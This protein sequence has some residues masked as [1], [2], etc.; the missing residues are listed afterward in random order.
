MKKIFILLM[1]LTTVFITGCGKNSIDTVFKDLTEKVNKLNSYTLS[2]NLEVKN[3]NNSYNYDVVVSFMA[4]DKFRVSLV[5]TS[6]NHEQVI[7]RNDEGVFVLTPSLNKSFKFQSDWP[8]N[9]SQIY[10][11]ASIIDDLN[12]DSKVEKV[13]ENG[14]YIFT[15]TVKYPNNPDLVKQ[16]VTVNNEL[17]IEKVE[18]LNSKNEAEM[19]FNIAKIDYAPTFDES[20]FEVNN[21]INTNTNKEPTTDSKTE[22]ENNTT[23]K[24]STTSADAPDTSE[25]NDATGT[26]DPSGDF[27]EDK[28]T[29]NTT[30]ETATLDDII[31]PLY[32][33]SG[34]VLEEQEKVAKTDGERVI[35][36]FGGDKGF[37]LVEETATCEKEF[38]VIPT[39]G[40]PLQVNDTIG[41]VTDNSLNWISGNV[42][43]Y[44][45]SD[46]MN[47]EELLDIANSINVSAV[48]SLK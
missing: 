21:I 8:Y 23:E 42:E 32:L 29:T 48:A 1:I 33:P 43:Y 19:T 41:A 26:K 3:D 44:I 13:E 24:D 25:Q 47:T 17:K 18:V 6:N 10:L 4:K 22:D 14:K 9:N 39:Y 35:L 12:N 27:A 36:T 38:T 20:Y 28:G 15:S 16:K 5:N 11:L 37:T 31:Y 45:V 34:T 40:E 30:T 2:G 7:L 46:V